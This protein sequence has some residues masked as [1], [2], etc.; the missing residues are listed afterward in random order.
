MTDT[1]APVSYNQSEDKLLQI[2]VTKGLLDKFIALTFCIA[3]M[4]NF[5]FAVVSLDLLH[6]RCALRGAVAPVTSLNELD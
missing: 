2:T 6:V 1:S 3:K 5:L 4:E